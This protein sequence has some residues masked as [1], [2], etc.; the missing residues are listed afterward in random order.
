MNRLVEVTY[1][2]LG[3][4]LSGFLD[5]SPSLPTSIGAVGTVEPKRLWTS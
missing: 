2:H 3:L 5:A 1:L 4:D